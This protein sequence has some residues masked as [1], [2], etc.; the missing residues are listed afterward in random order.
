MILEGREVSDK[1]LDEMWSAVCDKIPANKWV[2]ITKNHADVITA[3][4]HFIDWNCFNEG[5]SLQFNKDFTRFMKVE[6][7]KPVPV[8]KRFRTKEQLE[9]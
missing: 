5:F 2:D 9:A 1:F 4:K 8:H 7:K 3:V 6:F